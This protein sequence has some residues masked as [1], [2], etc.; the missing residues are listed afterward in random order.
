MLQTS[1][2]SGGYEDHLCSICRLIDKE[3]LWQATINYLNSLPPAALPLHAYQFMPVSFLSPGR[4]TWDI[5]FRLTNPLI[6]SGERRKQG[7]TC[8]W[9]GYYINLKNIMSP[10]FLMT[11]L[12]MPGAALRRKIWK[13]NLC[14]IG[15]DKR[16]GLHHLNSI[17]L[18]WH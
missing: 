9:C 13:F 17:H 18:V 1:W 16:I 14:T 3:G 10:C 2:C 15:A 12:V 8:K 7:A 4:T 5:V 6:I 11:R